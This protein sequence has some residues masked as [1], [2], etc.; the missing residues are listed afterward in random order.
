[1]WASL[2]VVK[3]SGASPT[4]RVNASIVNDMSNSRPDSTS[5]KAVTISATTD[6]TDEVM[7]VDSDAT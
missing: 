4:T 6:I 5:S 2:G 1:M 7:K 3:K